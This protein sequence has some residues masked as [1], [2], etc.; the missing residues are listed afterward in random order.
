MNTKKSNLSSMHDLTAESKQ[1]SKKYITYLFLLIGIVTAYRIAVILTSGF[2]LNIE[3]AYYWTWSKELDFGYFSKPPMI[4][5]VIALTTGVCGDAPICLK[6]GSLL[7]YP[8]T[9]MVIFLLGRRMFDAR[10]GF[11]AVS[12]FFLMPAVFLSSIIISTDVVLFLF[13]AISLYAFYRALETDEINYWFL[14]GLAGGLGLLTKYTMG[15]F[16]VSALIFLV[17]SKEDRHQLFNWRL[18]FAGVVAFVVLLPN[19]LWNVQNGFPTLE[20]TAHISDLD[21]STLH[22]DEL[23]EFFFGQFA[24]FGPLLFTA[25]LVLVVLMKKFWSDRRYRYLLIFSLPFLLII[26]LQALF[27]RANANWAA[28]TYVAGSIL[29]A[30]VL[31]DNAEKLVMRFARMLG[32]KLTVVSRICVS[33]PAHCLLVVAL[34]PNVFLGLSVYHFDHVVG[35]LGIELQRNTDPFKRVRGWDE[36]GEKVNEVWSQYP[37][38]HL[39]ADSRDTSAFLSYYVQPEM[40]LVYPWNPEG[41]VRSQYELSKSIEAM[42]GEDFLFI[43]RWADAARLSSYFQSAESLNDVNVEIHSDYELRYQVYYLK[44]FQGY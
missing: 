30:A 8:I 22:F 6:I 38:T 13:W 5:W 12:M 7:A 32:S 36:L 44:G 41:A 27:G 33:K 9:A 20:H 31:L 17:L 28:P 29:V 18:Y 16:A 21:S 10:V 39:L 43:T 26:C 35:V 1:G 25:L 11:I 14:A 40:T 23:A 19:I 24:V 3:E 4:A 15:V 2:T 37:G 34:V 42:K